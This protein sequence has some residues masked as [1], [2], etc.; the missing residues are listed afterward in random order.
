MRK[1]YLFTL[2]VSVLFS[3]TLH[4]QTKKTA[5]ENTEA[6]TIVFKSN[7]AVGSVLSLKV[8]A[9]EGEEIKIKGCRAMRPRRASVFCGCTAT[10]T[11]TSGAR[12]YG[13]ESFGAKR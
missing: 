9:K 5:D 11:K 12:F 6:N 10:R 13:A 8:A 3:C 7:K 2:L 1:A 4:A